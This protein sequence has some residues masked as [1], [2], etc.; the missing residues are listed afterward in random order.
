MTA[1][2]T[3]GAGRASTKQAAVQQVTKRG[4]LVNFNS[5]TYTADVLIMEA[6]SEY[7]TG[8]PVACHLDG[9][10]AQVNTPCLVFFF[11]E[12]NPDDAVVLAVYPNGTQGVPT[13]APGRI[14]FVDGYEQI[15]ATTIDSGDTSTFTLTGGSSGIPVGALGV[16]YKAFFTSATNGAYINLAPHSGTIGDYQSIGN[17]PASNA[18]LNGNGILQLDENGEIDIQANTG[19][20]TVTLYTHG[21][22]F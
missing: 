17:L 21:Y 6:T 1:R 15:N 20:C 7:L 5:G 14:T 16:I 11:D 19:N 9:T 18:Y 13:P 2:A 3:T 8:V 22:V 12:S 4:I 10:S